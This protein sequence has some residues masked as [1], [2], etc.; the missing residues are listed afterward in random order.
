MTRPVITKPTP[1]PDRPKPNQTSYRGYRGQLRADHQTSRPYNRGKCQTVF[2]PA[3]STSDRETLKPHAMQDVTLIRGQ[4]I[5]FRVK[6][7]RL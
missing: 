4:T 2:T 3:S 1:K 5:R 6:R 7:L